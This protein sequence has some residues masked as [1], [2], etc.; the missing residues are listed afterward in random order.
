MKSTPEAKTFLKPEEII[1]KKR[2]Y[3]YPNSLHF[4]KNPPHF[5]RGFMQYLYD[6]EGKRYT[7]FSAGVT[8]LNCGHSNP[9]ILEAV[10][11]QLSKLQ[12]TSIIYLTQ[13]MVE[14]AEEL[15]KLLPGDIK[16]TFFCNSGTEANEGALLLAR[17]HTGRKAFLA[18][19]GGL[20]GRSH[21]TMSVT[22]IPMWRIDPFLEEAVYFAKGFL[23]EGMPLEESVQL[24]LDS[25]DAI[26]EKYG[27]TI[28]ACIVEPI[29]GNGGIN[30]P[31]PDFFKKLKKRLEAYGVILIADEIQTGIGRTGTF[32]AM[33]SFDVVP[34]LITYAKALGN[35]IPIGAFSA[36]PE[37]AASFNKPSASTLGGN[38]VSATAGL[39][40]LRYMKTHDLYR[41]SRALGEQLKN[42]LLELMGKHPVIQDVRGLGLMVGLALPAEGGAALVDQ[43]LEEMKDRGFILGKTGMSRNVVTF[44]PPL[45]I[46]ETDIRDMLLHLDQVLD[47]VSEKE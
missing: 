11:D 30:T 27:D 7:D 18:F 47:Q 38:P 32:F 1:E 3:F 46:G 31:P 2:E 16:Q 20:H 6:H 21:L 14:L 19:E 15:A 12:H 25:V 17:M 45:V 44:Q 36:R 8:V 9:E 41:R 26:L 5:V 22:G 42:G 23:Q 43:I 4:Y 28:A 40:V 33:E 37:V 10:T 29:Q 39:A 24:S 13:P 35:G 34:D